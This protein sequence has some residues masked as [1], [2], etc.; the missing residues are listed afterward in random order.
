M[1]G[2]NDKSADVAAARSAGRSGSGFG[3]GDSAEEA[4]AREQGAN[5]QR[6][7]DAAEKSADAA[8]EAADKD[9]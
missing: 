5:E 6:T 7:A 1:S 4:D 9:D 8:E 2:D 3:L